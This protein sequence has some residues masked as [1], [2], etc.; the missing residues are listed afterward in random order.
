MIHIVLII[1]TTSEN[2]APTFSHASYLA[3]YD[4]VQET[5]L[6][7]VIMRRKKQYSLDLLSTL[8]ELLFWMCKGIRVNNIIWLFT[9]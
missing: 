2:T 4:F 5:I 3:P 1:I 6:H 8:L 7:Y 9:T